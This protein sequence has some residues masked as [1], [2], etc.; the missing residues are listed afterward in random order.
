MESSRLMWSAGSQAPSA[1]R[2]RGPEG[3]LTCP[4]RKDM[5]RWNSQDEDRLGW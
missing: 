4:T 1:M 5:L 3:A 2:P